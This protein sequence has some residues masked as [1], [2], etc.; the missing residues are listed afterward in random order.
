ML[1]ESQCRQYNHQGF[2]AIENVLE[3]KYL[4]GCKS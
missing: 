4:E 2:L 3:N 1:T